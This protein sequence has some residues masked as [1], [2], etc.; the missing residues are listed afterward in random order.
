MCNTIA[1]VDVF[2][3]TVHPYDNRNNPGSLSGVPEVLPSEV[4]KV[5]S[6]NIHCMYSRCTYVYI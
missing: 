5:Q 3:S 4:S 1:C 2:S 6:L